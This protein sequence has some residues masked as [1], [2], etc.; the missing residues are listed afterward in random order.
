MGTW[1]YIM[2]FGF[3][4]ETFAGLLSK[5]TSISASCLRTKSFACMG[6]IQFLCSFKVTW[7]LPPPALS[8]ESS[9]PVAK[10]DVS[11]FWSIYDK[12]SGRHNQKQHYKN[13]PILTIKQQDSPGRSPP[14]GFSAA[15]AVH[16]F[17]YF[18]VHSTFES[19]SLLLLSLEVK[20]RKKRQNLQHDRAQKNCVRKK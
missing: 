15:L 5:P 3:D 20:A 18:F 13:H 16:F 8:P 14:C 11:P 17:D 7:F 19:W 4:C 9:C 6:Q 1:K 12:V 10:A 2:F